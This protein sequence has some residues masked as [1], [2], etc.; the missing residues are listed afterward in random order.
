M[1]HSTPSEESQDCSWAPIFVRQS[2]FK[3]PADPTVPIIM[4]GPG[5]G[6]A[7]FRGFLQVCFVIPFFL[8]IVVQALSLFSLLTCVSNPFLALAGKI[9]FKR[10]RGETRP[11]YPLLRV[12]KPPDGMT[13]ISLLFSFI[14]SYYKKLFMICKPRQHVIYNSC[15]IA[16]SYLCA[17]ILF[18]CLSSKFLVTCQE[19]FLHLHH[20]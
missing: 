19:T 4:V 16:N 11:C 14:Y 17:H 3:L 2:N 7:P 12:Q 5:T 1:Q 6:L 18:Y 9:S 20:M 13:Y 10:R 8:P 15:V